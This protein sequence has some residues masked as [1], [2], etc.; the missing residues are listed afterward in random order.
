[1]KHKYYKTKCRDKNGRMIRT[2]DTCRT[3]DKTGKEWIGK[4][5]YL[6]SDAI[7]RD[8]L[9]YAYIFITNWRTFLH[10]YW[11]HKLEIINR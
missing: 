3:F 4:I 10:T 5:E 8:G 7:H 11:T 2:E 6:K 1:M 9:N